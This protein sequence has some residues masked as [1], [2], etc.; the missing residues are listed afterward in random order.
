MSE[1]GPAREGRTGEARASAA[2][3]RAART[4]AARTSAARA[5]DV[6][7]WTMPTPAPADGAF[8]RWWAL[9]DAEE[10]AQ[11]SRFVFAANRHEYVAA[12]ALT[13]MLLSSVAVRAGAGAVS[14]AAWRFARRPGYKPRLLGPDVGVRL[15]FNLSHTAGRVAVAAAAGGQDLGVD[16]EAVDRRVDPGLAAQYFTPGEIAWLESHP[17]RSRP[18]AFLRLWT[19]KEAYLKAHGGGLS[20]GLDSIAFDLSQPV[21]RIAAGDA[22]PAMWW[23]RQW[24]LGADPDSPHD[25]AHGGPQLDRPDPADGVGGHVLALASQ[26]GGDTPQ[27]AL[28]RLA[29]WFAPDGA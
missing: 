24:V 7:L 4:S 12:H 23:F 18:M 25:D 16:V 11:A 8:A 2:R 13:R 27:P 29:A 26:G 17:R 14:P 28:H 21:P 9:L 19:L 22:A 5:G 1:R 20:A 15:A 10:R 3:A 6:Q